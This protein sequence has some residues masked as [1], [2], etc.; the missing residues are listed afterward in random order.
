[1]GRL[2]LA[3]LL[4]V[5]LAVLLAPPVLHVL[6]VPAGSPFREPLDALARQPVLGPLY[7]RYLNPEDH[8]HCHHSYPEDHL[9]CRRSCP[10]VRPRNHRRGLLPYRRS[11][12][13]CCP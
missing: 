7:F 5:A 3:A 2:A 6:G 13:R 4:L 10:E 11:C 9:R 8:R 12:C 1:M